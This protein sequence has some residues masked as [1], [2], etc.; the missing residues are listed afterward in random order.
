MLP[1]KNIYHLPKQRNV[2]RPKFLINKYNHW[3]GREHRLTE[4]QKVIWDTVQ[5][6]MPEYG[7][8]DVEPNQQK[9]KTLTQLV[10][11]NSHV[12][13]DIQTDSSFYDQAV[14]LCIPQGTCRPV[15]G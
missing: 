11:F 14:P 13:Q 8:T 12:L 15:W 10:T 2:L 9:K 7:H 1:E 3:K 6:A 4:K 5:E